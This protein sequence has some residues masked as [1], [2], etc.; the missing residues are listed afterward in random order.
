VKGLNSNL[1]PI[2]L[3]LVIFLLA[4]LT[5]GI[6]SDVLNL[7]QAKS[8]L[9]DPFKGWY[10]PQRYAKS[11][12]YL[13]VTTR[14]GWFVSII[15]LIIM[16]G[17]WFGGGFG[18]L[19][20]RVRS[21]DVPEIADGLIYIGALLLFKSLLSLPM[22]IYATFVIESRF[23]FNKTTWKI[24]IKDRIKG[25]LLGLF[26]G[27]PL[28]TA[29]LAFFQYAGT[30]AW[31]YCWL[32]TTGF[33]LLMQYIA[34]TYIMPLFNRFQP[35]PQG[36]LRDAI[37]AYARSIDFGLDNIFVM[38]GSRRSTKSNAF[39]TGFG[40]HRRIVLFDTLIEKHTVD[41]LVAV[42]AHEMGHYKLRHILKGMAVGIVQAGAMFY[43]LSLFISYP[44]LFEAFYVPDVSVYAGLIFFG[45][46]YAPIDGLLALALKAFSRRNEYAADR[47]S[48]RTS[49]K[50]EAMVSALKRLSVDNLSNL[51]PH[52]LHVFL[53]YSHPPVLARIEAI[54]G[55]LN[56]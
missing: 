33:M 54:E 24:F 13:G 47:F 55:W 29:I 34:P 3:I 44:G 6:A 36:E 43:L 15:N 56:P 45:M 48:I 2:A 5:L 39:F 32:A 17:F 30:N 51:Q 22:S 50:G 9:P 19:D 49:G 16:L 8:T 11:Q 23:G 21:L 26:L 41:E 12:R 38:D 53:N 37:T 28:V 20:G 14:F 31:W 25:L 1:H 10:D 42:L 52:P 27:T 4:D 46:L 18:W 7:R 40:S 35:L